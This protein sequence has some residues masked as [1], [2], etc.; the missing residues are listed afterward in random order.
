MAINPIVYDVAVIDGI[1]AVLRQYWQAQADIFGVGYDKAGVMKIVEQNISPHLETVA[2]S[3]VYPQG[4]TG[5]WIRVTQTHETPLVIGAADVEHRVELEIFALAQ[6]RQQSH[7]Y[8][9]SRPVAARKLYMLARAAQLVIEG[10][11]CCQE[12]SVWSVQRTKGTQRVPQQ[13]KKDAPWTGRLIET[14]TVKQ[15][16]FSAFGSCTT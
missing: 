6:D 7:P 16:A 1:E 10:H 8:P 2:D 14:Y 15:R 13:L 9:S 12:D 5:C 11:L 3:I 4:W